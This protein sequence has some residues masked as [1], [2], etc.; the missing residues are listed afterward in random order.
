LL[1]HAHGGAC[2]PARALPT[3]LAASQ[4]HQEFHGISR[5]ALRAAL[6]TETPRPGTRQR[7]E[8]ATNKKVGLIANISTAPSEK[9]YHPLG[10][11]KS[12]VSEIMPIA[13]KMIKAPMVRKVGNPVLSEVF[14]RTKLND[15]VMQVR[16]GGKAM[17]DAISIVMRPHYKQVDKIEFP[18]SILRMKTALIAD[19]VLSVL[20]HHLPA[21]GAGSL[22]D[23][24]RTLVE[25]FARALD[26]TLL[27]KDTKLRQVDKPLFNLVGS[28][29][30]NLKIA[31]VKQFSSEYQN[32][33]SQ[34]ATSQSEEEKA[35]P[36][37][38][39]QETT[40]PPAE[41]TTTSK[42]AE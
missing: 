14:S 1:C 35:T 2:G 17:N 39:E 29:R 21:P 42:P 11:I 30:T 38:A 6:S 31:A 25:D 40:P 4:L 8:P 19:K 10:F 16:L 33:Q 20:H 5:D 37:P 28:L 22:S 12:N 24:E 18:R 36:Q 23:E 34:K 41:Q 27:V 15:L 7:Q 13:A 26:T 3:L 9:L 32:P